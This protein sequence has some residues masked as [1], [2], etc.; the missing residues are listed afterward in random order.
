MV[1]QSLTILVILVYVNFYNDLFHK[2]YEPIARHVR[3]FCIWGTVIITVVSGLQYVQRA[4][5][6]YRGPQSVS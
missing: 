4:V 3:D 5:A 6:L 2:G 1:F